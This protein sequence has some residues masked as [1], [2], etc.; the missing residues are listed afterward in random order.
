[1]KKDEWLTPEQ[2]NLLREQGAPM[3][4]IRALGTFPHL[5]HSL[6]TFDY[7]E[8]YGV[9]ANMVARRSKG[10]A[11]RAVFD[12]AEALTPRLGTPRSVPNFT[13]DKILCREW[14][15]VPGW[16]M[17]VSA[18]FYSGDQDWC[19]TA[20]IIHRRFPDEHSQKLMDRRVK[21]ALWGEDEDGWPRPFYFSSP[22]VAVLAEPKALPGWVIELEQISEP[23]PEP[24][25]EGGKGPPGLEEFFVE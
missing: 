18:E 25:L 7:T 1:M 11:Q 15:C 6:A 21:I 14:R 5:R 10:L 23:N 13:G 12:M 20:I 2:A 19:D 4:L 22:P 9:F 3:K 17:S 8:R 24:E 16:A